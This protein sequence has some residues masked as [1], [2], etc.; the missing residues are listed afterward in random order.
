MENIN[1][2]VELPN[3]TAVMILGILSILT[4]CCYGIP[5]L[6]MGIVAI[7]LAASSKKLFQ[8][9]PENYTSGSLKNLE[10]GR[11]CAIVGISLSAVYFLYVIAMFFI[12]GMAALSTMPWD[13]L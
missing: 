6:I 4:C 9:N 10:T 3:H 11:I 8:E 7:S 12:Y 2:Q 5:G 13:Q 1:K